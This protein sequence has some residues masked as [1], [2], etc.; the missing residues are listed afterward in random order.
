MKLPVNGKQ[1]K[2]K[3]ELNR[4]EFKKILFEFIK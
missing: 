2:I 4:S 1:Y 3:L